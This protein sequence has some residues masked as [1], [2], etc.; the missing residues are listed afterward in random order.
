M[1]YYLLP[2]TS[3]YL[4]NYID[5]EFGN[6]N[7]DPII[8][9]SLS[10]YLYKIKEKIS[11]NEK[12]W[13]INKKYTNPYEYIHSNI[14]MKKKSVCKYNPL[15]RSFFKMIEIIKTFNIRFET[16]IYSFHL[17]E[18][19]GGF[20]EALNYI[21]KNPNDTYIGMTLIDTNDNNIPSW[22]KSEKYLK[23]NPNIV[24]EY[25]TTK[26]GNILSLDN[27]NSC[28][29][30]YG[31]TMEIITGDGGFDFSSDFNK[32]ELSIT[33]LLFAQ[34]AFAICMQKKGGVFILKIFDSFYEHTID[35]IYILSSFYEKVYII[36]PQTSRYANSEKYLVCSNF[37]M[38]NNAQ[39]Y[40]IFRN[41]FAKM[42]NMN[43]DQHIYRFLKIPVCFHFMK[44][45]EEYNL[46]FGE[47][48]IQNIYF[49]LNLIN[50]KNKTEKIDS[51]IKVNIQKSIKW[52]IKNEIPYNIFYN[53]SNIFVTNNP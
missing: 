33:K 3:C 46:I 6:V 43:S 14:P 5:V 38:E 40:P 19:P 21:R 7:P 9:D 49:T 8:S 12:Q 45:I 47:K 23:E 31:S 32:Q 29:N 34:I 41:A 26:D 1:T 17:A 44:K 53:S 15:S 30:K 24:L 22:K 4:F 28:V 2:K 37:I 18:G 20:I 50:N 36:K 48:Q 13:D 42:S 27:F 25:G 10:M 11:E 39:T 52:C 51:L 35:I 16:P